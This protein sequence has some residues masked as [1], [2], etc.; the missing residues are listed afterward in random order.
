MRTMAGR[1]LWMVV[2][3]AKLDGGYAG[4]GGVV[5]LL[6]RDGGVAGEG[7]WWMGEDGG[8]ERW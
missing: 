8:G 4:K 7:R 2:R 6:V 1:Q 5:V 3:V